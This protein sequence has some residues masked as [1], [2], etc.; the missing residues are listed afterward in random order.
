MGLKAIKEQ[1]TKLC[2]IFNLSI[3]RALYQNYVNTAYLGSRLDILKN[4][5]YARNYYV[6]W[7]YFLAFKASPPNSRL[8]RRK[9]SLPKIYTIKLY[10]HTG[11]CNNRHSVVR[12]PVNNMVP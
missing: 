8:Y 2:L 6:M 9:Y 4:M 3:H 1:T 10:T 5:I 12:A 11:V 7:Y